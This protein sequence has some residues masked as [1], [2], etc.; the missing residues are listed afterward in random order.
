[1]DPLEALASQGIPTSKS[2]TKTSGCQLLDLTNVPES[3]VY[4][5]AGNG[6]SLRCC[7]AMQLAAMLCLIPKM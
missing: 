3:Q 5:M 1:M 4:K 7:G 2:S 6:M